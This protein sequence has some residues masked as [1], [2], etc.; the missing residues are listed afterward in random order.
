ML[1]SREFSKT[2]TPGT[3]VFFIQKNIVEAL[4]NT[5]VV[6]ESIYKI[7]AHRSRYVHM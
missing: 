4:G 7:N 3:K 2:D 5:N 1:C 6:V